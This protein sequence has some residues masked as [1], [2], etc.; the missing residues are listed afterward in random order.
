[1]KI[2]GKEYIPAVDFDLRQLEIFARVVEFGSFSKASRVVF[3]AQASVSERI[4]TLETMVGTR[5][6]DRLGRKVLPTKAGELLYKHAMLLLEMKETARLEIQG[7]LGLKGGSVRIGG[8][9]IPGEY[10][11]PRVLGE[12]RSLHPSLYVALEIADTGKIEQRVAEGGLEIAVIGSRSTVKQL[13][14]RELWKDELVVVVPKG[15]ALARRKEIELAELLKEPFIIRE[16]G[17]GT[18]RIIDDYLRAE[19]LRGT[20]ELNACAVLGSSTAVK[21]GIKGGLGVSIISLRAVE[22]EEKAG[23]LSALRIK[24]LPMFRNFY[25]VRDRRRIASPPCTALWDFLVSKAE[26]KSPG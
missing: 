5:L 9:T 21:E 24:G 4:A 1:L 8:S 11:L 20:E 18:S 3:L 2:S 23:V 17:S 14:V 12:F 6:L 16:K 19:G 13:F 25:L 7:F 22:T 26:G 15:H 10:I